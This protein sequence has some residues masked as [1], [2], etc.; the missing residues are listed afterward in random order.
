[1]KIRRIVL[2]PNVAPRQRQVRYSRVLVH[3]TDNFDALAFKSVCASLS[4]R[5]DE[6]KKNQSKIHTHVQLPLLG[7]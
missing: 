1:M 4:A 7:M 6:V 2:M 5:S 3:R